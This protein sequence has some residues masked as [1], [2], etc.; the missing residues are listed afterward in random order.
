MKISRGLFFTLFLVGSLSVA[1]SVFALSI[2]LDQA[3]FGHLNQAEVSG[4]TDDDTG[5]NNACGPTAALN[6]LV[7]L[8]TRYPTI[9]DHNLVPHIDN[10]TALQ[11][12]VAAAE[13]LACL[14]SC[15]ST[16]GTEIH[17]FIRGKHDY[18]EGQVPGMTIYR[19]RPDPNFNF[20]FRELSDGEDVELLFGFYRLN[21]DTGRLD[22]VGGHY[23]TLTGIDSPTNNGTGSIDFIDPDDGEGHVGLP[24]FFNP[25]DGTIR[26]T[27]YNP[28]VTVTIIDW[29]V[30]ESPVP[31]P[32]TW[33]LFGSGLVMLIVWR[34]KMAS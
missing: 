19:D 33:L 3:D 1:S 22:R 31:E 11:D 23:V 7:F 18:I 20:L 9:Y 15:N 16:D 10:N 14:M 13:T 26:N 5:I 6:S 32:S 21:P 2:H 8:E 25:G 24:T 28:G 34:R 27:T 30:S 4:C 17:D 29:A 12:Q